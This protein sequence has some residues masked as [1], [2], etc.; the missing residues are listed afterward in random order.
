MEDENVYLCSVRQLLT[1]ADE[2]TY[3]NTLSELMDH[4]SPAFCKYYRSALQHAVRASATFATWHTDILSVS[5]IGITKNV[6][7]EF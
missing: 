3:G 7:E 5:Y 2:T 1:A 6:C 4:W